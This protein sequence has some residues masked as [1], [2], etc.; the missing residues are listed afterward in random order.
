[1]K[2]KR[3]R[4]RFHQVHIGEQYLYGE[5][6]WIKTSETTG[7]AAS[8]YSQWQQMEIDDIDRWVDCYRDKGKV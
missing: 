1:M 5:Q 3:I 6:L 8:Y 7:R 4:I 2:T